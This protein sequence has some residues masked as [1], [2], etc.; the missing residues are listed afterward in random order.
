MSS[1]IRHASSPPTPVNGGFLS[2]PTGALPSDRCVRCGTVTPAGV[3][4]CAEHNPGGMRGPSATQMHATILG[5]VL[6]GVIIFLLLMRLA[7][8]SGEP[9]EVELLGAGAEAGGDVAVAFSIVNESE[10]E[11]VADCRVTRDGVPRP[12]DLAFRT[13]RLPAGQL[14]LVERVLPPA[15]KAS[16]AYVLDRLT[17][18]CT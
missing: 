13:E 17:V 11:R 4:L 5:G 16:V 10:S 2:P 14:V 3:A 15:P 12:D 1:P 6:L 8:G 18:V 9:F 7:A